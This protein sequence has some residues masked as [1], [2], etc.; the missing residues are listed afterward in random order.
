[1]ISP[2]SIIKLPVPPFFVCTTVFLI[3][4]PGAAAA[5]AGSHCRAQPSQPP[6]CVPPQRAALYLLAELTE[7]ST[8]GRCFLD[9]WL[10]NWASS[11]KLLGANMCVNV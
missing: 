3:L 8:V 1:M 10:R 4:G 9:S 11:N 5:A 6:P 7:R 2:V